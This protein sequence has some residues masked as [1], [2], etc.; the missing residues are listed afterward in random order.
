MRDLTEGSV[1]KNIL[2]FAMP[3]LVGHMFQQLY[4]FVDQIIVGR[5]LGKEALAAVGASFPV[6]F[7]L[8]ALI[9][10]IAT[11]GTMVCRFNNAAPPY[12]DV[13][14][15]RAAQL[16]VDNNVVLALGIDGR[17]AVAENHHVGPMHPEYFALPAFKRDVAQ[18]KALLAE[19]GQSDHEFDLISIDDDWRRNS[20]D[21]IAAQMRWN[22]MDAALKS[23]F[24]RSRSCARQPPGMYSM[25]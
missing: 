6:I 10:G 19:A 20:T 2:R 25:E 1:G 21:A 8:I 12:D 4:T 7:T 15:R 22:R 11:G 24:L 9:I 13:R 23:I 5:Y 16:A 18:S 14:V 17:G 3:M